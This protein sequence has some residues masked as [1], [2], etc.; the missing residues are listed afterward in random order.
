MA[1]S[2][3]ILDF[4]GVIHSYDSGWKGPRTI[5]DPIVPGAMEFIYAASF[6][7]SLAVLSSRSHYFLG[8]SAMKQYI[9]N[10]MEKYI[11]SLYEKE[12]E[13]IP[14]FASD[15][16]SQILYI[17]TQLQLNRVMNSI[18]FPKHKPPAILSI[19]DRAL[20]FTGQWPSMDEIRDFKPWNK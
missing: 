17:E 18:S 16:E 7:F 2:T 20:T 12:E 19:D 14:D 8:R 10:G 9:R 3:I 1:F 15:D 5:P 4:D 11:K 13:D 6:H